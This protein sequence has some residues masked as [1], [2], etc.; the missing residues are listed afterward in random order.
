[1]DA[2]RDYYVNAHNDK[3]AQLPGAN[4]GDG[5]LFHHPISTGLV[6]EAYD[7]KTARGLWYCISQET[8]PTSN[9]EADA[10]WYME[11][12][13]IDFLKEDGQWK[14]WHVVIATDLQSEAGANYMEQ[15]VDLPDTDNAAYVEF[16]TPTLSMR[17]HNERYNWLDNYP[18][19]PVPYETFNEDNSYGPEGH[20]DYW[21]VD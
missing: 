14:I 11:K 4:R 17:V 6:Q 3:I 1:M 18:P 8:L 9:N 20:P 2:I 21:E 10:R 16:G 5:C 12:L 15:P 13:A 7:G 19:A